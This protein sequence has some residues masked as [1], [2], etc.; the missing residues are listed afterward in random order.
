M[1]IVS[2]QIAKTPSNVNINAD[3]TN[4]TYTAA[5]HQ[6]RIIYIQTQKWISKVPYSL[7]ATTNYQVFI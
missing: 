7:V 5:S 2:H 4:Q 3:T 1:Q 6:A